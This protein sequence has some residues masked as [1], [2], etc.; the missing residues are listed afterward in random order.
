MTVRALTLILAL[1]AIVAAVFLPEGEASAVAVTR[2][3]IN[4]RMTPV[5]FSDG[6]SFRQLSGEWSGRNSR[7]AGFNT[8]ESYGPN[9]SWGT[10]HPFELWVNAKIA[11]LN[12][13][14]GV[15]H[16]NTEGETD[17][18]G[19]VLVYCPDLAYD[20]IR[21]GLAHAMQVD[22]TPT[23]PAYMRAQAEAIRARRGMWAHGV[24]GFVVT[25]LHSF[26]ED[27]SRDS[28][29]NRMVS[30]RDGHTEKWEHTDV[31]QECQTVCATEIQADA[32]RVRA[33]ARL[34]RAD[35]RFAQDLAELP[36]LLVIEIVDRFARLEA[37]PEWLE[38]EG[39][40]ARLTE[41]LA[42]ARSQG[43]LGTARRV[44]GACV[45]YV[46]F[47]R[48]YGENRASCLDGHGVAPP[49]WQPARGWAQ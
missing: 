9:H 20:Q 23:Q 13:K 48:R 16:C 39:L 46:E 11:T 33:H 40:R 42:A 22:D 4:G 25:S 17:T 6:D 21:K 44:R 7:L 43:E 2:V 1:A 35:P 3:Y 24:P 37:L 30:T 41:R 36:N 15:W 34:L 32:E 49:G 18:Y 5:S 38:D 14:R 26:D 31:Y 10:W 29:Y 45:L 47:T 27:P 19:R 28:T 12:A 8:L